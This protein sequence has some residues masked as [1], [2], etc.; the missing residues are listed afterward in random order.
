MG[1]DFNTARTLAVLFEM[2][3][4]INDFKSGNIQLHQVKMDT[5]LEFQ[6]TYISFMEEILGL[7]EEATQNDQLLNNVIQVLIELRKKARQDRNYTLSD[8]IR[9]D[10]KQAGVQL[11]DGKDGEMS[12][13]LES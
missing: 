6:K 12:Y 10:L 1:D 7:Q 2:A 8:K 3:S 4:R 13:T 11:M 5:F 9:D